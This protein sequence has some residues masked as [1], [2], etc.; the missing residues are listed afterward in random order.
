M[1]QIGKNRQ[2]I[3]LT[4]PNEMAEAVTHEARRDSLNRQAWL[5]RLVSIATRIPDETRDWKPRKRTDW[6]PS[7]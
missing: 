6:K 4:L 5:R 1:R 3:L 7:R 2:D